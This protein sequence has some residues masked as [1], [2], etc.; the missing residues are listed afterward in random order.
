MRGLWHDVCVSYSLRADDYQHFRR[1]T[2]NACLSS[3]T[4]ALAHFFLAAVSTY[5]AADYVAA[6]GTS[7]TV[8][9]RALQQERRW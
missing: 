1:R 2:R 5:V 7:M 4:I 8:P 9:K 3:R 6:T